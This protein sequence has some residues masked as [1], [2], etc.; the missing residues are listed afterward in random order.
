METQYRE[1]SE[2]LLIQEKKW[3]RNFA[4]EKRKFDQLNKHV[5]SLRAEVKTLNQKL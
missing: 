2:K 3:Q 4:V 5:E 1:T